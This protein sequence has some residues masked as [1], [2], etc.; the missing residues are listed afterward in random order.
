MIQTESER[1]SRGY[2]KNIAQA[3]DGE[4]VDIL[5]PKPLSKSFYVKPSFPQPLPL[6]PVSET[7]THRIGER[8]DSPI[9]SEDIVVER[10][11]PGKLKK[12][13]PP[14][15]IEDEETVPLRVDPNVEITRNKV[16]SLRSN[17]SEV[18]EVPTTLFDGRPSPR[19]WRGPQNLAPIEEMTV[20]QPEPQPE[21]GLIQTELS[22]DKEFI[23]PEQPEILIFHEPV[24]SREKYSSY[25]EEMSPVPEEPSE[26]PDDSFEENLSENKYAKKTLVETEHEIEESSRLEIKRSLETSEYK[27]V[28]TKVY[29]HEGEIEP[30]NI[31]EHVDKFVKVE[32]ESKPDFNQ[33][34]NIHAFETR[35]E[36][37]NEVA[38][39]E[40]FE[41]PSS[42][43]QVQED[44]LQADDIIEELM[45]PDSE[46]IQR[47]QTQDEIQ[48]E[49]IKQELPIL[50]A[51][52]EDFMI[53]EPIQEEMQIEEATKEKFPLPE[54]IQEELPIEEAIREFM[55]EKPTQEDFLIEEQIQEEFE[56]EEAT[57]EKF[58]LQEPILEELTIEE[59][60]QEELP[61]EEPN[62]LADKF[63]VRE[64]QPEAIV[65]E[66]KWQPDSLSPAPMFFES[67]SPVTPDLGAESDYSVYKTADEISVHSGEVQGQTSEYY[68]EIQKEETNI[69]EL[70]QSLDD[71]ADG[72]T[73]QPEVTS[74]H[75]DHAHVFSEN[76]DLGV[77]EKILSAPTSEEVNLEHQGTTTKPFAD[78][79]SPL[80]AFKPLEIHTVSQDIPAPIRN[81]Q[82]FEVKD[83]KSP[84]FSEVL[85]GYP[86]SH[87]DFSTS[88]NRNSSA[89]N[90]Y[91]TFISSSKIESKMFSSFSKSEYDSETELNSFRAADAPMRPQSQ[92][93]GYSSRSADEGSRPPK[94]P[95]TEEREPRKVLKK[96]RESVKEL[97]IRLEDTIVPLSPDEVPGGIR[98]FPTKTPTPT[99]EMLAPSF[100]RSNSKDTPQSSDKDNERTP[101]NLE[102][103]IKELPKLEPFPF[104]VPE[105]KLTDRPRSVPPPPKP[106]KFVPGFFTDSEYESE[107]D[108]S[109]SQKFIPKKILFNVPERK[110]R[111]RP[112]SLGRD[113]PPPVLF[114]IPPVFQGPMRPEILKEK[115]SPKDLAKEKAKSVTPRSKPKVVAKFLKAAGE[116]AEEIVVSPKPRYEQL[117]MGPPV[118]SEKDLATVQ[119]PVIQREQRKFEEYS[120]NESSKI[121]LNFVPQPVIEPV[122]SRSPGKLVK[123]WPPPAEMPI[124]SPSLDDIKFLKSI[125]S[126]EQISSCSSKQSQ[127]KATT[128]QLR[129]QEVNQKSF[130]SH[131]SSTTKIQSQS[132]T[133]SQSSF[134]VA[135]KRVEPKVSAF[136]MVADPVTSKPPLAVPP[137]MSPPIKVRSAHPLSPTMV[138]SPVPA[139]IMSPP[140][141]LMSPVQ[142][143]S[144][145]PAY[146]MSPPPQVQATSPALAYVMSPPPQ[147]MSPVQATSPTPPVMSPPPQ[148]MSPIQATSPTPAYVISPPP[149]LMSPVQVT[150]PT[151]AYVMSPPPQLMSPIQA[152]SPTP[153]YVMSPPPQ[154]MSPIQATSPAPAYVMS[155][156]PQ[157]STPT[158]ATL[159]DPACKPD[160]TLRPSPTI[161]HLMSPIEI[162]P[163]PAQYVSATHATMLSPPPVAAFSPISETVAAQIV[164]QIQKPQIPLTSGTSDPHFM[165]SSYN[166]KITE[167]NIET[168]E[169]KFKSFTSKIET[170][171]KTSQSTQSVQKKSSSSK[172]VSKWPTVRSPADKSNWTQRSQSAERPPVCQSFQLP[173]SFEAPAVIW[174][175]NVTLKEKRTSWPAAAPTMT[176]AFSEDNIASSFQQ[177]LKSKKSLQ[178]AARS[179]V[180]YKSA[181]KQPIVKKT[182]D[183]HQSVPDLLTKEV[184]QAPRA[185][186]PPA[187]QP[188][189]QMTPEPLVIGRYKPIPDLEPFP[190]SVP[191]TRN[192]HHQKQPPPRMPSKFIPGSFTESEYESD[193]D[194]SFNPKWG[195]CVSDSESLGY[196]K[197]N[198][199]LRGGRSRSVQKY[200]PPPPSKFDIPPPIGGPLRPVV[201]MP[202]YD[203]EIPSSKET[204]PTPSSQSVKMRSVSIPKFRPRSIDS[205]MI[206]KS[207]AFSS[208][209]TSSIMNKKGFQG[210]APSLPT[211]VNTTTPDS[212]KPSATQW[213]SH[214]ARKKQSNVVHVRNVVYSSANTIGSTNT[215]S[216]TNRASS[217]PNLS[218]GSVQQRD[219]TTFQ[220]YRT[221]Q[222]KPAAFASIPREIPLKSNTVV[223]NKISADSTS[224]SSYSPQSVFK[225]KPT[226]PKNKKKCEFPSKPF[227][228]EDG[229]YAADTESTLP[230]KIVKTHTINEASSTS[231][232]KS[233]SFAKS[234][235]SSEKKVFSKSTSQPPF[236]SIFGEGIKSPP[237]LSGVSGFPP[238]SN[239]PPKFPSAAPHPG[240]TTQQSSS[241]FSS[242]SKSSQVCAGPKYPWLCSMW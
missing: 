184:R 141:Q 21:Y 51:I 72:I 143:T 105:K 134:Q 153:A 8:A 37:P 213:P 12:A 70:L 201:P 181:F 220:Q 66:L 152:T 80:E 36:V 81:K 48:L 16:S 67:K 79:F 240:H 23:E 235:Y 104:T 46:S 7:P 227:D 147:L 95:G 206:N 192:V 122:E 185:S 142:A 173:S 238:S 60:M 175:S 33:K 75:L 239:I 117:K 166:E 52:Q 111:V 196:R 241:V 113:P 121:D 163:G 209:L 158:L 202:G 64:I 164:T 54:R 84:E 190:F 123:Q 136:Q 178:S 229:G 115:V 119:P 108:S 130:E 4:A 116:C 160:V 118:A 137:V 38:D 214:S 82:I 109:Y 14:L 93:S 27:T 19:E 63:D 42:L 6:H 30:L 170:C 57:K 188:V 221:I 100:K 18:N 242:E 204:T 177:T 5:P 106:T 219:S 133:S 179:E 217:I 120:V 101:D 171:A 31:D 230:R 191:E 126:E 110:I 17:F 144:P 99:K 62:L 172:P 53:G 112:V 125:G 69:D 154:I 231:F 162:S 73:N 114:D 128:F 212:Y 35:E 129:P 24:S 71:I 11:P 97:A 103:R 140:P 68:T 78:T 148:L 83:E 20:L 124:T 98:M 208:S 232:M 223:N 2:V 3:I 180:E 13:W 159:P 186:A 61:I 127:T 215:I 26:L 222:P 107:T 50:E 183:Q 237:I 210:S 88:L 102:P 174:S 167:S 234:L 34:L 132:F 205:S 32:E 218:L 135:E 76:F 55:I 29:R 228:G 236:Q 65:K 193:Y 226:S 165:E 25:V 77:Q 203:S 15:P 198:V 151:P 207:Q 87:A 149:Q 28:E 45:I 161:E 9:A 225:A 200:S 1:L 43:T 89:S 85:K 94:V 59:E 199:K 195:P 150:S 182:L 41:E 233:E 224:S 56:I 22:D 49:T 187:P 90:E 131:S 39:V 169:T 96:K 155:P 44:I 47:L 211:L 216:S 176:S 86:S 197:L 189:T 138:T 168:S 146:F 139:Y 58:S 156:P 92:Q 74:D 91:S 157:H 40:E 145:A 194:G 10:R